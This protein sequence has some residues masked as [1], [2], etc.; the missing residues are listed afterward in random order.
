MMV[1]LS[2]LTSLLLQTPTPE[3]DIPI[4]Q[5]TQDKVPW[6]W[7]LGVGIALAIAAYVLGNITRPLLEH[8]GSAFARWTKSLG[9]AGAF[10]QQYLN[11]LIGQYRHL[12]TLPVNVLAAHAEY[13]RA[14]MELEELYTPLQLDERFE[15]QER[16]FN[17]QERPKTRLRSWLQSVRARFRSDSKPTAGDIGLVIQRHPRLVIRGDPGSGKTTLLR[18]L[19]LTCARTLRNETRDGDSR[20][21]AKRRLA[22]RVRRFPILVPLNLL[23][24][25]STWPRECRLVDEIANTLPGELRDQCPKDFFARALARGRC[26]V[27]FDGFDELGSRSARGRM[28]RLIDDLANAYPGEGNLFLVSTRIV[29]YEGQLNDYGFA[30]R[31]IQELD[32]DAVRDLVTR[33]NR[34]TAVSEGLGR[35]EQEKASLLRQADARAQDLL[36]K[37]NRNQRLRALTADPLLLSLVI[38]VHAVKIEL[39]EQRHIL[40]R[41]CVEILTERWQL[42]KKEEAGVNQP[43]AP[44]TLTLDQKTI[45]LRAIAL[46]MQQRRQAEG[47]SA[48]IARSEVEQLI[49][50]KLPDFVAAYLPE[51]LDCAHTGMPASRRGAS[52]HHS[53]GK[54]HPRRAGPGCSRRAGCRLLTPDVSRVSGCR[55]HLPAAGRASHACRERVQPGLARGSAALCDDAGCRAD[56]ARMS[57]QWHAPAVDQ[58]PA[59]RPVPRRK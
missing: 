8:I 42:R 31:T 55:R 11:S 23:G 58:V 20:S 13:Q 33:R 6:V 19:T 41:D 49:A 28:A 5:I 3:P 56:P 36:V 47:S 22:W 37:L 25:V 29:G 40:Y 48:V 16:G 51:A 52:R 26:L 1:G 32:Q 43:A 35:S 14:V 53:G 30:V 2:L 27:M 4:W 9:K 57:G 46:T 15:D 21:L 17:W 44:D 7:L 50:A 12:K 39:P 10:R 59:G 34:A 45:L 54:R 24:D 38:V 18:F